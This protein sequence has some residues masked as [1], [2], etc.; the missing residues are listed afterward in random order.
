MFIIRIKNSQVFFQNFMINCMTI[1]GMFICFSLRTSNKWGNR[2]SWTT[3][4]KHSLSSFV[5]P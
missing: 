4:G 2:I 1:E 5:H 3:A